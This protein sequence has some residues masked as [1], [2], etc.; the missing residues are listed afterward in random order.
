MSKLVSDRT[1]AFT[2]GYFTGSLVLLFALK[3]TGAL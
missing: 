3:Y 2:I 1:A